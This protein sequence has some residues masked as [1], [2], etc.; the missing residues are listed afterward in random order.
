VKAS[1]L[2]PKSSF[3]EGT[4]WAVRDD[5]TKLAIAA[6]NALTPARSVADSKDPLVFRTDGKPSLVV[7]GIPQSA[8][9]S[10]EGNK[11][12]IRWNQTAPEA[13][14]GSVGSGPVRRRSLTPFTW[15]LSLSEDGRTL[16]LEVQVMAENAESGEK[17]VFKRKG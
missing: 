16:V 14:A 9:A 4:T 10:R 17:V 12:V 3:T 5:G 15:T 8:A 11:V 2:G 7:L 1:E 6:R 13:K